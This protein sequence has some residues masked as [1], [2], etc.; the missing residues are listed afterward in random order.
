MPEESTT[1]DL[2]ELTRDTFE[3]VNRGDLDAVMGVYAPDAVL[4]LTGM[5]TRVEGVAA[6]RGF[7]EDWQ[8]NFEEW[9]TAAEELRSR[10]WSG[11]C[12]SPA[13]R[14]STRHRW[15]RSAAGSVGGEVG[16]WPDSATQ[17]FFDIDE[18]RAAAE[19]LAESRG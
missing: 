3:A 15:P 12:R 5:G 8:G 18:A 10:R 14:P 1:P 4:E 6:I 11:L 17:A 13:E 9:Q 7:Y 16:G 19:R 2:V